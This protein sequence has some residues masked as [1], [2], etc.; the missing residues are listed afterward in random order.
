MG[1]SRFNM[2]NLDAQAPSSG[3]GLGTQLGVPYS[4]QL[5]QANGMP[6][7]SPSGY[8]GIGGPASIPTIRLENTFNPVVNF[9]NIRGAHTLKFGTSL[10]RRQIIDFQMN[11]GNGLFNFDTNFTANPNSPAG[12]G[13]A[14]AGLL[15]GAY[16][17]LSQDLQLV[18]AGYRVVELGTYVADDWR[19]TS[20]LTLNLGLRYELLPPPV[21]VA[22]R[23]MNLNNVTGKVMIAN[24]NSG[25][26]VGIETQYK[27]FA[28]RF[29]FAYQ[30]MPNTVLRGGF[31]MFYN[32]NGSGGGLYRMHRYLPFAAS[33][34]VTVNELAPNYPKVQGGLPPAPST[35]FA[36]VSNNPIW[37]TSSRC[38]LISR[39]PM[40]SNSTSA[41]N[42]N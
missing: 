27:L 17:S 2:H 4:N 33:D 42:I 8:T 6:I 13:D 36:T 23:M 20:R 40:R 11:Q 3:P 28:P 1:F 5:P 7:F 14:M 41:W 12:T 34:A 29:G 26:H 31:G 39:T 10:V 18:W 30:L 24:F 25:R 15:L 19:V 9:T 22:D 16:S 32:A 21:E 38:R 35:D 37:K